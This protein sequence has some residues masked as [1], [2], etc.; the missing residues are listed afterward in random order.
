MESKKVKVEILR[1]KVE[2]LNAQINDEISLDRTIKSV[3]T[4]TVYM[5]PLT[6]AE[7]FGE[8][9]RCIKLLQQFYNAQSIDLE[10]TKIRDEMRRTFQSIP[11]I[12]TFTTI[13]KGLESANDELKHHINSFSQGEQSTLLRTLFA[14]FNVRIITGGIACHSRDKKIKETKTLCGASIQS[15][16]NQIELNQ[17]FEYSFQYEDD[18]VGNFVAVLLRQLDLQGKVNKASGLIKEMLLQRSEKNDGMKDLN[19]RIQDTQKIQKLIAE[20]I[21]H[22]QQISAQSLLMNSKLQNCKLTML[23][24]VQ[25]LKNAN[26]FQLMSRTVNLSTACDNDSVNHVAEVKAFTAANFDKFGVASPTIEFEIK[27]NRLLKDDDSIALLIKH[28]FCD[29]SGTIRN[30]IDKTRRS[31]EKKRVFDSITGKKNKPKIRKQVVETSDLRK[32]LDV[33]R[34]SLTEKLDQISSVNADSTI[35][36]NDNKRLYNYSVTNPLKAFI[37]FGKKFDGKCFKAYENDFNLYYR[38]I[39]DKD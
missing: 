30:L 33:N 11:N 13:I 19:S 24:L 10:T 35:V 27:R 12:L 36:L 18:S 6:D 15:I 8:T 16:T 7:V 21:S 4:A 14:K 5:N 17:S 26:K 37:P 31:F 25:D 23:H 22:F 29:I 3:S 2:Q 38:M 9:Q 20:K 32:Q 34:C 28:N 1:A 39:K